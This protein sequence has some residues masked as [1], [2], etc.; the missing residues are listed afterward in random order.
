MGFSSLPWNL[1]VEFAT[2]VFLSTIE[3]FVSVK[4]SKHYRELMCMY[5]YIYIYTYAFPRN[6]PEASEPIMGPQIFEHDK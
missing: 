4:R 2:H 6:D 3:G 1:E 5:I